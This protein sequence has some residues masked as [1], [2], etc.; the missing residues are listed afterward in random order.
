MSNKSQILVL[1]QFSS[2]AFF[3]IAGSLFT[4]DFWLILQLIGLGLGG[5]GVLAMKMGNF[6]IQPEVKTNAVM[7]SS[8]PYKIIRNPMYSGLLLFFGISVFGN[9]D[10]DNL[11]Y[12]FIRLSVFILLTAVL[13]M[14]IYMEEA[15]LTRKFGT[16]Y[17]IFKEKTYRLIP[18]IY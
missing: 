1:I 12:S 7:V 10:F 4:R 11:T 8:G 17:T 14:K 18:F 3:A 13:I 6:N 5:W 2:F 9:F 16:K 15:F